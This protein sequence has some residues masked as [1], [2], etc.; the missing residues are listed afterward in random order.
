MKITERQRHRARARLQV[1]R[2]RGTVEA[3]RSTLV[4][5]GRFESRVKLAESEREAAL[6]SSAKASDCASQ[7]VATAA[8]VQAAALGKLS[9]VPRWIRWIFGA[10]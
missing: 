4:S 5:C 7:F 2:I 8:E 3:L 9:R 1:R 10:L 6:N